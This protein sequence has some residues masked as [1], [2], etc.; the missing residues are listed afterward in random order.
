MSE[1]VEI[2]FG[3]VLAP[4]A[5]RVAG[6]RVDAD[7]ISRIIVHGIPKT[8]MTMIYTGLLE[9][10]EQAGWERFPVVVLFGHTTSCMVHAKAQS[11]RHSFPIAPLSP[12][13]LLCLVNWA[14][15]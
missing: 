5:I 13:S 14:V 7:Y 10:I 12:V 15:L 3:L 8:T 2:R 1:S 9:V 6:F 4:I 11:V